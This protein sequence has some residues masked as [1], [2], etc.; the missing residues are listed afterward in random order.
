[1]A[2]ATITMKQLENRIRRLAK[3]SGPASIMVPMRHVAASIERDCIRAFGKER[4]PQ[5]IGPPEVAAEAGKR[6]KPLAPSTIDHRVRKAA[7]A[8]TR[9]R[10]GLTAHLHGRVKKL[11]DEGL[12]RQSITHDV[13]RVRGGVLARAGVSNAPVAGVSAFYAMFH[14]WGTRTMPP[15]PVVGMSKGTVRRALRRILAKFRSG[16]KP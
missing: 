2:R 9:K 16:P 12:M 6:W 5:M 1:M 10:G 3:N 11:Q 13:V 14:Q 8:D 7:H 15:R 4:A